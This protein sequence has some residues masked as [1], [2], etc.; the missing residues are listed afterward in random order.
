MLVSGYG[1]VGSF[2]YIPK[3]FSELAGQAPKGGFDRIQL[4]VEE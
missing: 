2:R 4:I 3:S 1:A